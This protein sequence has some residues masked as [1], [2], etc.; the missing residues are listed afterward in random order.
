[1]QKAG[2]LEYEVRG[3]GEPV[4]LIHGSHVAEAF[5]P[6]AS[7]AVLADRYRLIR[8]HR[9]GFAG[10][11]RHAGPFS[12]EQQARDAIF[13]LEHLGVGRAH[14]VGHSYGAVT[15]LQLVLDAPQAVHSIVL[16][17]PP[18]ST[19][20]ETQALM[21]MFAP[22][23]EKYQSGDARGAVEDFMDLIGSGN[24]RADLARILPGGLEQAVKDASTF[25]EV[26]LPALQA[27]SFDEG[28][29]SGISQPALFILGSESGPLFER[30]RELFLSA[31]PETDDVVLPGLDH[32]LQMRR[33]SQVAAPIADFLARHSF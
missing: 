9:R 14:V 8:Y 5:A 28:K 13:L 23:I 20:T 26:E 7:E 12:I 27:W 16:I 29:V 32:L 33:P 3:E 22:L 17:E 10:S 24:W 11:D 4:L 6:L 25:F 18:L 31:L 21:A 2:G 1:M 15:T 19:A 30:P